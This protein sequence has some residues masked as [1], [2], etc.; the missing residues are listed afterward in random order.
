MR[1]L[2]PILALLAVLLTL[3]AG[4]AI[5]ARM[6]TTTHQRQGLMFPGLVSVG[7]D[8]RSIELLQADRR[9]LLE[10][11]ADGTWRIASRDG[12]PADLE[13][14]RSLISG[15]AQLERDQALTRKK[16]RHQELNLAWPDP[17]G[18]SRLV[19]LST[20]GETRPIEILLGQE[21][22]TPRSTYARSLDDDQTWRCRGGVNADVDLQRWMRR[23]LLSLPVSEIL[24]AE[25]LGLQVVR[26]PDAV[27]EGRNLSPDMFAVAMAPGSPWSPAQAGAARGALPDWPTRLEFDDVRAA[28]TDFAPA[29]D[30]TLTFEIKGARLVIE[31]RGEGAETWFRLRVEPRTGGSPPTVKPVPGD[32]WIPDWSA[33]AAKVKG[34]EFRMPSWRVS[35]LERLRSD[36][37]EPREPEAPD[38]SRRDRLPPPSSPAP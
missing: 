9:V 10:R 35:Q 19:R 32:P 34:W 38:M 24:G 12:Y 37:P 25:W 20:G 8:I 14:V 13:Q 22:I 23:D 4:W 31:G 6:A 28:R 11:A 17:E 5:A 3:V 21:R 36:E 7:N 1:R 16:E 29:A 15:L 26:R 2:L 30:R 27:S 18:R 33:F